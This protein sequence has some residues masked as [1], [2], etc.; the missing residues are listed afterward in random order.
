MLGSILI[1][2]VGAIDA[3]VMCLRFE[4]KSLALEVL[5]LLSVVCT[6]GGETAVWE[7]LQGIYHLAKNR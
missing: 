6:F 3:F 5:Q 1:L 4:Y 7:V 2:S